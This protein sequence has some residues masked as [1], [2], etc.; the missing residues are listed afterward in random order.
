LP[1]A[2]ASFSKATEAA[3]GHFQAV[4]RTIHQ[5]DFSESKF[6]PKLGYY[7]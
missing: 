4:Q 2:F 6:M 5:A 1:L 3:L 7:I